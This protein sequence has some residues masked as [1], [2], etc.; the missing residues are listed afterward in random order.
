L[1]TEKYSTLHKVLLKLVVS[2]NSLLQCM[3]NAISEQNSSKYIYLA[4]HL[5]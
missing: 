3:Q 4:E 5:T 1:H 2:T